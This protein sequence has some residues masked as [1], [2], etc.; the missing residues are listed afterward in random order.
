MRL[1]CVWLLASAAS[2]LLSDFTEAAALLYDETLWTKRD[3]QQLKLPFPLLPAAA[4]ANLHEY[5]LLSKAGPFE[6]AA[7]DPSAK[8]RSVACT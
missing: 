4:D 7:Y 2:C 3:W 6:E 8:D 5:R 1:A